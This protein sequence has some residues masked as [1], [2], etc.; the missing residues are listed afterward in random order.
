MVV[1]GLP[2]DHGV[3]LAVD[4]TVVS[5]LHANGAPFPGAAQGRGS[6]F[7][8]AERCKRAAY[9]ELCDSSVLKLKTVACTTGGAWNRTATCLLTEAADARARS[10][11]PVLRSAARRA[12]LQRWTAMLSVCVQDTLAA[13]LVSDS[14]SLLDSCDGQQPLSLDVW[15]S[16]R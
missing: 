6:T 7:A 8:R 11:V 5:C 14:A 15:L 10:E 16:E 13:T 3:P 9:P 4:A 12:W 1:T 2:L